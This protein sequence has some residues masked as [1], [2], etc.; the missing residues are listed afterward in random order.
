[1]GDII[2]RK[3]N[4]DFP[5]DNPR[6]NLVYH[7]AL[8]FQ[9]MRLF[10]R[11]RHEVDDLTQQFFSSW[12]NKLM[13]RPLDFSEQLISKL[14]PQIIERHKSLP[15][16]SQ[17]NEDFFSNINLQE[18]R[19]AKDF[20]EQINTAITCFCAIPLKQQ[21]LDTGDLHGDIISAA[22]MLLN[23]IGE[24][25]QQL[26][27]NKVSLQEISNHDRTKIKFLKNVNLIEISLDM[28]LNLLSMNDFL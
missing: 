12:R 17:I 19:S 24:A 4:N 13:H 18:P 14:A 1:M 2:T 5:Y 9:L 3:D 25:V 7:Y 15:A 11:S 22:S 10:E 8:F 6:G 28:N 26:I 16:L 20:Q 23:I 27:L 21:W